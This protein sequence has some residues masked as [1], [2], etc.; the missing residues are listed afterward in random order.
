MD[1]ANQLSDVLSDYDS[2]RDS[3]SRT[4]SDLY[5]QSVDA[6]EKLQSQADTKASQDDA[7]VDAKNLAQGKA[8]MFIA[9][10]A[11][12]GAQAIAGKF[13][14]GIERGIQSL[15]QGFKLPAEGSAQNVTQT[16][17][18]VEGADAVELTDLS[19]EGA[20][21]GGIAGVEAAGAAL[22]A[23]GIGAAAGAVLGIGGLVAAGVEALIHLFKKPHHELPTSIPSR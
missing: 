17:D 20:A 22:D 23:T 12:A 19:A 11:I 21:E 18:A 9:Q 2:T 7:D 3:I 8:E 14:V 13:G 15:K 5:G 16:G 1:Y 6:A 10:P 4:V